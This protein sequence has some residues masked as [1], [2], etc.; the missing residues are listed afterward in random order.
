MNRYACRARAAVTL[1]AVAVGVLSASAPFAAAAPASP[2]FKV[3]FKDTNVDGWLTFCN[4]NNQPVTS[5]SLDTV[6]FA[7]KIVGSAPPPAGYRS[8]AA[9]ATL[10]AYQ[11]IKYVDPGNWSG[12][13]LTAASSF[14]NPDHP[15]VQATNADQPLIG[16]TQGYPAHW[17]GLVDIRM[18]FTAIAKPQ[19]QTPYEAAVLRISGNTWTLV[20]GGG[21]SCSQSR[22]VSMET[23]RLPKK[24]LAKRETAAPASK[25][26]SRG[27]S[28]VSGAANQSSGGGQPSGGQS[29]GGSHASGANLAASHSSSGIGG[30]A[31]AGIGV[32]VLALVWVAIGLIA[33]RRRR[34]TG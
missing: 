3:P 34:A 30:G 8:S 28:S 12:V 9:R 27:N 5:G 19:L 31:L 14:T 4:R 22:G 26:A 18:M 17:D 21:G 6:P 11:P 16:F 32:G 10:Y 1:A 33:R 13:A 20:E 7:W 23:N 2:G 15:V 24:E 29:S 25:S